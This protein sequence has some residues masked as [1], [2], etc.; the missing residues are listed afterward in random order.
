MRN[1]LIKA[2]DSVVILNRIRNGLPIDFLSLPTCINHRKLRGLITQY[3]EYAKT[4]NVND[5][6]LRNM[7]F[8]KIIQD[9]HPRFQVL[10]NDGKFE[11]IKPKY[12]KEDVSLLSLLIV[13]IDFDDE[14][15]SNQSCL[16]SNHF[17][18]NISKMLTT[19]LRDLQV[20]YPSIIDADRLIKWLKKGL[21]GEILC[22]VSL[23]CPDYSVI[24]TGDHLSPYLHTFTDVHNGVGVIAKRIIDSLPYMVDCF[25]KLRIKYV[26][27]IV[28]AD[29]ESLS[30]KNLMRLGTT[31]TIF[32]QK[33]RASMVAI[34]KQSP[35]FV[36]VVSLLDL[37]GGEKKWE[38]LYHTYSDQFEV[39]NFGGIK[40]S[41]TE[42]SKLALTRKKLYT[43]WYGEKSSDVE[44]I[45]LFL[46]QAAEY[47]AVSDVFHKNYNNMAILGADHIAFQLFY[48][49]S[50]VLPMLYLQRFY[51]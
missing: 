44:Y 17:P 16:C 7:V 49:V 47:A 6:A 22:S 50:H 30:A 21:D 10:E 23:V 46:S 9:R 5:H 34:K 12:K 39:R 35:C 13:D 48:Q 26:P 8:Y 29:Y 14:Q 51:Q 43:R 45:D 38:I 36:E 25:S 27:V 2:R 32:Q 42:L 18:L 19:L 1:T 3:N 24:S 28:M 11:F 4:I 20:V 33:M 37:C 41:N 15:E 31:K 40:L